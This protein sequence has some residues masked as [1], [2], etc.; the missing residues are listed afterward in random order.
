MC[1]PSQVGSQVAKLHLSTLEVTIASFKCMLFIRYSVQM[2]SFLSNKQ[3]Q[4]STEGFVTQSHGDVVSLG[5]RLFC[6]SVSLAG[7]L[8][9]LSR[10]QGSLKWVFSV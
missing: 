5:D 2:L 3:I 6:L 10:V 7:I 8:G 4:M 9:F 1:S